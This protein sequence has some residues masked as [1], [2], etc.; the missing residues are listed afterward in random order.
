MKLPQI[1]TTAKREGW[2]DWIVEPDGSLHP[3][4]ERALLDGCTFD[5]AAAEKVMRFYVKL[6]R[7]PWERGT[8]LNDWELSW[9]S[10]LLPDFDPT[11]YQTTKPFVLL[12]WWYRRVLG[13]L[14]GW[15]RSDGRRRYDKGFVTTGKKT[16][17]SST[18]AGLPLYM[19]TA[20]GVEEAEA[21]A[22]AVDRDQAGI[23]FGKCDKM[24]RDSP[25]LAEILR[26]VPSQKTLAYDAMGSKFEAISS[27]ADS[28]EGREPLLLMAD[29]LHAWRDRRF[30]DS[31]MYG[32]I[33]RPEAL[34]LMITTAGDDDLSIGYEEYQFAKELLDPSNDFYSMSHFAFIAEAGRDEK[35][36][37]E[38]EYE[39]DDPQSWRQANP[40]LAEGVGSIEK[41]QS[42]CDEAKASPGKKRSFI[43]Y[44]CNCW[45]A[46]GSDVWLSRERWRENEA[47]IPL[48]Q[49][50]P[51]WAALDLAS[52]EDLVALAMAFRA[53]DDLIDLRVRFWMPEE[54][55]KEKSERWRVP[56]LF[57]WVE[58]GWI[59]TT[60]GRAIE[61]NVL[62][63]AISGVALDE[64]GSVIRERNKLAIAERYDLQEL[65]FDRWRAH[66]LVIQQLGETD[67][68]PVVD[69]GQGFQSMTS[70]SKEF[71]RRVLNGTLRHD[72]N[73]VLDW[74][75]GHC[76]VDRDPADNIKPNKKKSRHKIDGIVAAVMAVGRISA[77]R[78]RKK[79]VYSRRGVLVV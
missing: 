66:D 55:I 77:S 42:K 54:G 32:D 62:R 36:G 79:S 33:R 65:A 8:E 35:T 13:Q 43:R 76:V 12:E 67:G 16:G 17:K 30:F 22:T 40:S 29:E 64:N 46:G 71:E 15:K 73:P 44:I 2:H 47:T 14:F 61:S 27:D 24:A 4:T 78:P 21:Y 50:E 34:F 10:R 72:G 39:W 49:G 23:I 52:T 74:M 45:V 31:L 25:A 9:T 75:V 28:A 48:H 38:S 59:E 69:H 58:D 20:E 19:M 26:R 5:A 7:I 60:P 63:Y 18:L 1:I 53:D 70:P 57:Q 51:C 68:L 37:A 11:R 41:L 56:Q 6:L 3:N